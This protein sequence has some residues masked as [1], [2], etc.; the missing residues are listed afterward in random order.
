VDDGAEADRGLAVAVVDGASV[1]LSSNLSRVP[2]RPGLTKWKMDQN[3]ERRFSMG[4]PVRARRRWA[5]S[6]R[7]AAAVALAGFLMCC[8]SSRIA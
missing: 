4:V 8:A 7:A 3:S 5:V 6:L 1:A 2:R